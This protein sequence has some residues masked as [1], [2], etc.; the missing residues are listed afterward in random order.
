MT[1][2]TPGPTRRQPGVRGNGHASA[3]HASA[4]KVPRLEDRQAQVKC[5]TG[6]SVHTDAGRY[7]QLIAAPGVCVIVFNRNA[8]IPGAGRFPGRT[9]GLDNPTILRCYYAPGG[10]PARLLPPVRRPGDL[11]RGRSTLRPRRTLSGR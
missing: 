1:G 3:R 9:W 4:R 8:F 10:S 2:V 5:Q 7:V 11:V 6:C